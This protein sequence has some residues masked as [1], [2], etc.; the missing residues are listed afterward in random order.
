[1]VLALQSISK[2]HFNKILYQY[3]EKGLH[4]I[5]C[6]F[7]V[8]NDGIIIDDFVNENELNE[9][10]NYFNVDKD[11]TIIYEECKDEITISIIMKLLEKQLTQSGLSTD[12]IYK[13]FGL[14]W[15][16]K[17]NMCMFN[18]IRHKYLNYNS[19]IKFGSTYI[20]DDNNEKIYIYGGENFQTIYDFQK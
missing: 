7:W 6:H 14:Y 18:C 19:L 9:I 4:N 1:M 10:K 11:I 12:N 16:S 5:N 8:E 2:K 13:L 3:N 20:F 15:K 17:R